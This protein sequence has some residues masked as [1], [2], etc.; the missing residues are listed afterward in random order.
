MN[1]YESYFRHLKVE[2]LV[3]VL[4]PVFAGSN[5]SPDELL[6]PEQ[7]KAR[8]LAEEEAG[9]KLCSHTTWLAVVQAIK[10]KCGQ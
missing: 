3:S 6:A 8:R 7:S 1:V 4:A 9:V 10:E 2:K 5:V